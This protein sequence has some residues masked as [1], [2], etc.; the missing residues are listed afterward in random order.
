MF[1][2]SIICNKCWN[3]KCSLRI[4]IV[5]ER[6][7]NKQTTSTIK[8]KNRIVLEYKCNKCGVIEEK[9]LQYID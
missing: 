3:S 4:K 2:H 9:F 6:Q 8:Y 7:D 1:T 5:P